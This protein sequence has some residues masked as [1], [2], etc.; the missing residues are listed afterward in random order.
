VSG[1]NRLHSENPGCRAARQQHPDAPG[2]IH[3]NLNPFGANDRRQSC[4]AARGLGS[5]TSA[6]LCQAIGGCD[7]IVKNLAVACY[8]RSGP[9]DAR[10][11]FKWRDSEL[12]YVEMADPP[13]SSELVS[14]A[15]Y[16][17]LRVRGGSQCAHASTTSSIA[18]VSGPRGRCRWKAHTETEAGDR[19]K[20]RGCPPSDCARTAPPVHRASPQRRHHRVPVFP[21]VPGS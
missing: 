14:A 5:A 17:S 21:P 12:G 15:G 11:R 18:E 7:R 3:P 13:R 20:R 16:R 6:P 19:F 10:F 2:S 8:C 1:P 9:P 4:R